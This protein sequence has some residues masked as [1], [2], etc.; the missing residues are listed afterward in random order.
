MVARVT[1]PAL[2]DALG[3]EQ[4]ELFFDFSYWTVMASVA[5]EV[6][7]HMRGDVA[8]RPTDGSSEALLEDVPLLVSFQHESGRVIL[9][10]FAWRAQRQMVADTLLLTL[11]EGLAVKTTGD[12]GGG[13]GNAS[14]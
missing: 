4:V 1:D 8:Y 7:V 2:A 9:S 5:P 13:G 11:V 6:T 10:S 12:Q 3:N 14:E